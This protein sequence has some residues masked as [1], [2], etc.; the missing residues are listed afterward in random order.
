MKNEKTKLTP[1]VRQIFE[2]VVSLIEEG[3]DINTIKVSDIT[4]RAGIGKGTAY[5]YF[6]T[7]EE[8]IVGAILYDVERT[9]T[10]VE[11]EFAKCP[12]FREKFLCALDWVENNFSTQ[13]SIT[14]F[15]NLYQGSYQVSASLKAEMMKHVECMDFVLRRSRLL[16]QEG[17]GEGLFRQ[18][19]DLA[20]AGPLLISNLSAFILFLNWGNKEKETDIDEMK[21]FLCESVIRALS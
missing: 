18:D 12:G 5:E 16:I 10:K 2:A 15:L 19:L 8:I 3:A 13:H 17:I 20:M 11:E 9:L 21:K 7:K 1:K 6:K 4:S 14:P